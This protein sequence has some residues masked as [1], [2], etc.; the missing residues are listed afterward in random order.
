MKEVVIKYALDQLAEKPVFINDAANGLACNCKCEKCDGRLEAIQGEV[1]EWHFRHHKDT[2]CTGAQETAI[3][4]LAKQIICESSQ[5]I[6][7]GMT[8]NYT[9]PEQE[10]RLGSIIPDVTVSAK[11]YT[12]YFEIAITNPVNSFKEKFYNTGQHKSIEIDLSKIPYNI[13]PEELR[14]L[15]LQETRNKRRIFWEPLPVNKSNVREN[16][17]IWWKQPVALLLFIASG[18]FLLYRGYKWLTIKKQRQSRY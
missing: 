6:I 17:M 3:H 16:K 7:P 8:L 18:I 13:T 9:Q 2:N 1:Y 11:D 14:K 5:V 12:V 10:K 15:I 4:K